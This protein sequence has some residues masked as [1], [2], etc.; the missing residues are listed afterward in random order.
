MGLRSRMFIEVLLTGGRQS[1][2]NSQSRT[3]S[4]RKHDTAYACHSRLH[5]N[6]PSAPTPK[7]IA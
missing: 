4:G 2:R 6:R 5:Y 3:E 7:E 1:N